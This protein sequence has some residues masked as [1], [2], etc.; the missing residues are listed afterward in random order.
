MCSNCF[1][2]HVAGNIVAEDNGKGVLG[3]FPG[4]SVMVVKIFSDISGECGFTYASNVIRAV[5]QCIQKGANIISMSLVGSTKSKTEQAA[6]AHYAANGIIAVASS[7]NEGIYQYNYPSSYP[8][9]ISVAAIDTSNKI[10]PFSTFNN[11]VNIAAPG[12]DVLSTVVHQGKLFYGYAGASQI[13]LQL[14]TVNKYPTSIVKSKS[15]ICTGGVC[16][17]LCQNRICI[18]LSSDLAFFLFSCIERGGVAAVAYNAE[19]GFFIGKTTDATV[20]IPI[21]TTSNEYGI[22]LVEATASGSDITIQSAGKPYS[23]WAGTSMACP[24]VSGSIFLLWNKYPECTS[25]QILEAVMKTS[26]DLGLPGKDIY[27]GVGLIQYWP[28]ENYLKQPGRCAELKRLAPVPMP[29]IIQKEPR[30][31]QLRSL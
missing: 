5:N 12:V 15:C 25:K 6:F 28:A 2:Q 9:V 22:V 14:V 29:S 23:F 10:A 27:Y 24:H 31:K 3:I 20:T 4:A 8:S 13:L 16:P 19:A 17:N 18:F 7:G 11:R 30:K 1:F 21:F 26:R